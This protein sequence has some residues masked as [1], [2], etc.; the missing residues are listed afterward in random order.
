MATAPPTTRV[1]DDDVED[2]ERNAETGDPERI[3]TNRRSVRIVVDDFE[4]MIRR[5][6][7]SLL[8]LFRRWRFRRGRCFVIFPKVTPVRI[9]TLAWLVSSMPLLVRG[10]GCVGWS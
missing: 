2:G 3:T 8:L 1:D 10:W 7:V 9:V 4:V 6:L 5:T